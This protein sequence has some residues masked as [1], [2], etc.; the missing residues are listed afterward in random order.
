MANGDFTLGLTLGIILASA[1]VVSAI[2][3]TGLISLDVY[4]KDILCNYFIEHKNIWS[5][6]NFIE[7]MTRYRCLR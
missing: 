3:L 2:I 7:N 1:I 5:D 6:K 4:G